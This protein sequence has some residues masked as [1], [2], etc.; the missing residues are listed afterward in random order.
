MKAAVVVVALVTCCVATAQE[1]PLDALFDA[2]AVRTLPFGRGCVM[3]QQN[4][5]EKPAPEGN[6]GESA[7]KE[8]LKESRRT[9]ATGGGSIILPLP[10]RR[11]VIATRVGVW[12]PSSA[13]DAKPDASVSLGLAL[14]WPIHP[15]MNLGRF[16]VAFDFS[17]SDMELDRYH[18][19]VYYESAEADYYEVS[20]SYLFHPGGPYRATNFYLG[21]GFGL[22]GEATSRERA[23]VT[24]E[25]DNDSAICVLRVGWDSF[26][27]FYWEISYRALLDSQRN[28]EGML[29]VVFGLYF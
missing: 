2:D 15:R 8:V 14:R 24:E 9:Y 17:A 4:Q 16:E 5:T 19:G 26:R 27:S 11:P 3:L 1:S 10:L 7:E 29:Q 21:V 22:A 18:N 12:L 20:L 28:M 6:V 23:G 25:W 13:E